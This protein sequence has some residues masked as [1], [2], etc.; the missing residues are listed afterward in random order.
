[1]LDVQYK[2]YTAQPSDYSC[3]NGTLSAAIDM[4]PS[5]GALIPFKQPAATGLTLDAATQRIYV[6]QTSVYTHYLI[7]DI[8]DGNVSLYYLDTL[9]GEQTPGE[10]TLI[11]TLE[12]QT[13]ISI[14][15]IGNIV[16]LSTDTQL[17]YFRWKSDDAAYSYIGDSIP[18]P[19]ITFALNSSLVRKQYSSTAISVKDA[20]DSLLSSSAGGWT[21]VA[22]G[23][24]TLSSSS[25]SQ[26]RILTFSGLTLEAN[27]EYRFI[28]RITS[29]RGK[30]YGGVDIYGTNVETGEVERVDH[31]SEKQRVFDFENA[32]QT[33]AHTDV[34]AVLR[35]P[36][37]TISLTMT[38]QAGPQVVYGKIVEYTEDS[39]NA[40]TG[41]INDFVA[42]KATAQNRFI[43]PFFVRYAV[44]LYDGTHA[45]VSPP[46]LMVPNTAYAPYVFYYYTG[47]AQPM[48]V[49]FIADLQYKMEGEISEDW[50]D[51]ID[52]ID[53]YVSAPI[54]PY[55]QS[56]EYDED[57]DRFTYLQYNCL[58]N[59]DDKDLINNIEGYN[60]T[61]GTVSLSEEDVSSSVA[62]KYGS[63]EGHLMRDLYDF[64]KY[65]GALVL[66][67]ESDSSAVDGKFNVVQVS[68]RDEEE[69]YEE[70][71]SV[72]AYYRIKQLRLKD[73]RNDE[74][75]NVEDDEG[76]VT[77][78]IDKGVLSTLEA[79]PVLEE[80]AIALTSCKGASLYTYNQ[81]LH[82]YNAQ[83]VYEAPY[84]FHRLNTFMTATDDDGKVTGATRH[85][86]PIR[87]IWVYI[88]T[89]EGTRCAHLDGDFNYYTRDNFFW[90]FYPDARAYKVIIECAIY[91]AT[92]AFARRRTYTAR[93]YEIP[94]TM[95]DFITGAY[96]FI[97]PTSAS[98]VFEIEGVSVMSTMPDDVYEEALLRSSTIYVSE[99]SNPFAFTASA[100]ISVGAEEVYALA[101][102]ARPL[103]VG[104]FGEYPLY[105]FTSEGVWAFALADT[106]VYTAR[107]PITR[108]ICI[109]PNNIAQLDQSVLFATDRGIME[110]SGS[111]C[112]CITDVI[113]N[114][115]ARFDI[116]SLQNIDALLKTVNT[117]YV[118]DAMAV[119]DMRSFMSAAVIAYDYNHSRLFFSNTELSENA[120]VVYPYT[121]VL[122]LKS[123][124][125][126]FVSTLIASVSNSY[127]EALCVRYDGAVVNFAE[128]ETTSPIHC[129]AL[130]RPIK[131]S[132]TDTFKTIYTILQRG[133]FPAGVAA[134]VGG[135]SPVRQVLYA[136]ND[137]SNWVAVSSSNLHYLRNYAGTA[138]KYYRV[139]LLCYLKPQDVITGMSIE[140]KEKRTNQIR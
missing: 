54:F 73:I 49:A 115:D 46:A 51:L 132:D 118:S 104:Q 17:A 22:S 140:A 43:H 122:D 26:D 28:I 13:F 40:V 58:D 62:D 55:D 85:T 110:I 121:Y 97:L 27:R 93:Y 94:L 42:N 16:I 50:D 48:V 33:V 130:T 102:A 116:T 119:G 47:K 99:T 15:A 57:E 30:Y 86:Y 66:L 106:G 44:R 65:G 103:S 76:F 8:A 9:D 61:I 24:I 105:A 3:E 20:S 131:I 133:M 69:M 37:G 101:A 14:T 68:A 79:Q 36:G 90:F 4:V 91:R 127:P 123:G 114:R 32:D 56:L 35:Q 139:L 74:G 11:Y 120:G 135:L 52:G 60:Y 45:Y 10:D 98:N 6:H 7:Y 34:Y 5:N 112:E 124:T 78:D 136:S 82:V 96:A 108:D 2:G 137:M 88:K 111:Q 107:Q 83:T 71:T 67:P 95:H 1:M 80:D 125:W 31:S 75:E 41:C 100:V 126:S 23:S 81:R 84:C 53:I 113:D 19:K 39:F 89:E 29:G 129:A 128:E 25:T 117:E 64:I 63:I 87:D 134:Q 18:D 12:G 70:Y 77:L 92:K 38:I 59:D 21:D 138:Y 72:S 109:N